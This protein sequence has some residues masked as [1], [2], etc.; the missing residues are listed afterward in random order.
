MQAA[1]TAKPWAR[2]VLGS[3][4][5]ALIGAMHAIFLSLGTYFNIIFVIILA[6]LIF[7]SYRKENKEEIK[8]MQWKISSICSFLLPLSAL[9]NSFI[10]TGMLA[11]KNSDSSYQTGVAIGGILGGGVLTFFAFIIGISLGIVFYILS[12]KSK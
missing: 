2:I 1:V 12:K 6:I 11:A 5:P 3:L 8:H 7:F 9:L 4:I 10:I